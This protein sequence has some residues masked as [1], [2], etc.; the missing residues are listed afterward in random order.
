MGVRIVAEGS[1]SW[2]V[3]VY[4]SDTGEIIKDIKSLVINVE[5][6]GR[7]VANIKVGVDSMDVEALSDDKQY[8]APSVEAGQGVDDNEHY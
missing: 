4:D 6:C 1:R 5:A 8:P 7:V 3:K 2:D